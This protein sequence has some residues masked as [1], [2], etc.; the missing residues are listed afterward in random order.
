MPLL[1][2]F[3][4]TEHTF[5]L[6]P[7]TR[8]HECCRVVFCLCRGAAGF[9]G[10]YLRSLIAIDW[11]C[12]TWQAAFWVP[13]VYQWIRKIQC[14]PSGGLS[15]VG[16][17]R[18]SGRKWLQHN[19]TLWDKEWGTFRNKRHQRASIICWRMVKWVKWVSKWI[20]EWINHCLSHFLWR[21]QEVLNYK[22]RTGELGKLS[23]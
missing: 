11:I 23:D 6:R 18:G 9:I 22:C 7:R 21:H 15:S 1:L 8:S 10:I 14:L 4:K 13:I 20:D 5:L 12:T 3:L 2:S 17:K 16:S 19:V